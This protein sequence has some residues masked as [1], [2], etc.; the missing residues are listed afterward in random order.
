MAKQSSTPWWI[1][2]AGCVGC[3]GVIAVAVV[4]FGWMFFQGRQDVT[5]IVEEFLNASEQGRYEAA[6]E[7]AGETW[8]EEQSLEQFQAFCTLVKGFVGLPSPAVPEPAKLT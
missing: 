5:P 4:G 6:Y 3:L 8:K 1:L 2:G 7:M